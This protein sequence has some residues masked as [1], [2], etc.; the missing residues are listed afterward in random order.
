VNR[1]QRAVLVVAIGVACVVGTVALTAEWNRPRGGWIAYAPST[2]AIFDRDSSSWPIWR[3]ALTWGGAIVIWSLAALHLLRSDP[4]PLTRRVVSRTLGWA[5]V[6]LQIGLGVAL[7][8]LWWLVAA[9]T[10]T[11]LVLT[12]RA[13]R[14]WPTDDPGVSGET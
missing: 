4:A 6:V 12:R 14:P 10:A 7:G 11:G 8:W 9:C 3:D 2:G 13:A 1:A 5:V